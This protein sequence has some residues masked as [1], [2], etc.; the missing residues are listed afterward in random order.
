[1]NYVGPPPR[2]PIGP[3]PLHP[4]IVHALFFLAGAVTGVLLA[5]WVAL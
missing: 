3:S 4:T 5:A 1:M 2:E